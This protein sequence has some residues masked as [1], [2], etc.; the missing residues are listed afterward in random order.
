MGAQVKT[1]PTDDRWIINGAHE[2]SK[3]QDHL[4]GFIKKFVLCQE[5]K[6]PETDLKITKDKNII[7][8]CK[9][10]GQRTPIDM[11]QRLSG[12][13][14]KNPPNDAKKSKSSKKSKK[15]GNGDSDP[16]ADG[17]DAKEGKEKK[18]KK[19][20]KKDSGNNSEEASQ[21]GDYEIEA[22]SDDEFTKRIA[23]EA[24]TL[25]A[26]EVKDDDDWAVDMSE[27]AVARRAA[28]VAEKLKVTT[29]NDDD[30][31]EAAGNNPYEQLGSWI[32][33]ERKAGNSIDDVEVYKKAQELGIEAKHKT[34]Q[35]LAQALFTEKIAT[36]IEPR[37]PLL[38]KVCNPRSFQSSHS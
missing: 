13:I 33:S 12:F 27:E 29:L 18:E 4:D 38:K 8:D 7:R 26:A 17:K 3:L 30:D 14:L 11:R 28:E 20:K 34:L 22:G 32:D 35:V 37:A 15:N 16:E 24:K 5:C 36:E 1:N 19:E 23:A 25:A 10:C 2:A 21:D 31:D 9:A 6:N